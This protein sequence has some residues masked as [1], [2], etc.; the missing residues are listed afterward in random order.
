MA[1]SA[2][3]KGKAE[4]AAQEKMKELTGGLQLPPGLGLLIK[5]KDAL[6]IPLAAAMADAAEKAC[7]CSTCGNVDKRDPC[8]IC[9]DPRRDAASICVVEEV[10]DLWALERAGA[11]QGGYHVLGGVL[12]ALDGVGPDDLNIGK[13]V[14]RARNGEVKEIILAM[15]ATVDGQATAH[16]IMDRLDGTGIS[17][18]RLAHG[19]PVGG[20][21]D[22]LDDGTLAAAM[23]SRRPF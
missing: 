18:S 22:Y 9:A 21:L 2:D 15:N 6:L 3:A 16:Y 11:H 14:E 5:K 7:I 23:K 4:R 1:A 17:I 19:V 8:T 10:G 13:L 20:E 12:S